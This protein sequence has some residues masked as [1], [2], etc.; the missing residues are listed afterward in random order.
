M[1]KV[2]NTIKDNLIMETKRYKTDKIKQFGKNVLIQIGFNEDIAG[3][4]SNI[5]V[6]ADLRNI[7]S[8]GMAGGCSLAELIKKV[9][10]G[11]VIDP[12]SEGYKPP[13]IEKQKYP[14]IVVINGHGNPGHAVTEWACDLL[15][16]KAKSLGYAKAYIYNSTHFG[17]AGYYS[18]KIALTDLAGKVT[19]L[20]PVWAKPYIENGI[21]DG[22][23]KSLGTNPIAWSIPYDRGIVT[24]DMA[25]TQRAASPAVKIAKENYAKLVLLKEGGIDYI[26]KLEG[27]QEEAALG[28]GK[29]FAQIQKSLKEIGVQLESLPGQYVFDDLG[30]EVKFPLAYNEHY[31]N[32]YSLSPLG[33]TLYGYK[34]FILDLLIALDNVLGG[35]NP[36]PIPTGDFTIKGRISHT[37]EAYCLDSQLPLVDV[38]SRI[39]TAIEGIVSAGGKNMFLPGQKEQE[40][41]ESRLTKGIPYS[42]EQI[43]TFLRIS[44]ET[45]V[46]FDI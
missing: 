3:T 37:V 41:R 6:E 21:Y 38:K 1:V 8:H 5:L 45:G 4:V 13:E 40:H 25:T 19:T 35:G 31:N 32:H 15:I 29:D 34:G 10:M 23:K 43:N 14:A 42:A 30:R 9:K 2:F 27:I 17:I 11:G 12:K 20:S 46:P 26:S 18:E 24:L 36:M 16:G 33:G 7:F 28:R 39:G 22:V 44:R